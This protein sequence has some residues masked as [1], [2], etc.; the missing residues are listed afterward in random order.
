M[1][2]VHTQSDIVETKVITLTKLEKLALQPPQWPMYAL[3]AAGLV[4]IVGATL[5][6]N[7]IGGANLLTAFFAGIFFAMLGMFYG[8]GAAIVSQS[9]LSRLLKAA[10]IDT[11]SENWRL[12]IVD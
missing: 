3:A 11:H 4:L 12:E 5:W 1:T 6:N 2:T 7:S 9:R 10:K 8:L